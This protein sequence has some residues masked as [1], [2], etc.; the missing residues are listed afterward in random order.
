MVIEDT[1]TNG[2]WDDGVDDAIR[3][4]EHRL[5]VGRIVGYTAAAI[6]TLEEIQVLLEAMRAR[7]SYKSL[8]TMMDGGDDGS[9]TEV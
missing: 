4:V 2:T 7:G 9:Q 1:V 3:L 5:E 6:A 8:S